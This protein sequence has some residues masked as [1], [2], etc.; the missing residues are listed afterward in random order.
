M[1]EGFFSRLLA[2]VKPGCCYSAIAKMRHI[3]MI[4]LQNSK[5]FSMELGDAL[6]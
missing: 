3:P 6:R 5:H 1:N 2:G 4:I